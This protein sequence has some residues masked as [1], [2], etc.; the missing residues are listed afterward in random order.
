[1]LT[2]A[3]PGTAEQAAAAQAEHDTVCTVKEL[4][5]ARREIMTYSALPG[6]I[7]A[8]RLLER[9]AIAAGPYSPEAAQAPF[10]SYIR[11]FREVIGQTASAN[12][13]PQPGDHLNSLDPEPPAGT[14]VRDDCGVEWVNDGYYPCAWVRLNSP[15]PDNSDPETWTKIAGNYGPVTIL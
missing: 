1:M 9:A 10:R 15:D 12:L 5:A 2:P 3:G 13:P 6:F 14:R 11:A 4:L 8:L 7:Q